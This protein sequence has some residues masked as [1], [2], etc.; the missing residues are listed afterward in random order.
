VH[1]Q[2]AA[3]G[4]IAGGGQR[5]G[6]A[7]AGFGDRDVLGVRGGDGGGVV[8]AVDGDGDDL[9]GG[10]VDRAH[11][12]RVGLGV[13]G[14]ERVGGGLAVVE[15]VAPHPGG[16]IEAETAIGAGQRRRID[17][18][19][20]RL[21]GV[22]VVHGQRAARGGIAGGG[23]RGGIAGAGFGDRDVLGVRG[24]DGGGV[25]GAV[26]GDGDDLAGGAGY[27][28]HG[29]LLSFPTRRSSDLGGGLAVVERVAPHPGGGIEAE[30]AIGAGQ[31]RRIDG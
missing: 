9:A 19:E 31:R 7:G 16:G 15:R 12:E 26:D 21:A 18:G 27:R 4:G 5:G 2:R 11:G 29:D 20:M 3:R 6:I 28:A 24:G 10:A 17:G 25:V 14:V 23:Q 22:D 30:T 13:A 8:G 1:G